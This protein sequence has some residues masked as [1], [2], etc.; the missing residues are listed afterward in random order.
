MESEAREIS[1]THWL[2][3]TVMWGL[4]TALCVV[5]ALFLS[6]SQVTALL[7]AGSFANFAAALAHLSLRRTSLV[8]AVKVAA[9]VLVFLAGASLAYFAA[10][11]L[12]EV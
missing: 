10:W 12:M 5:A 9:I 2:I 6:K 7:L 3:F 1:S 8:R 11:V 4:M